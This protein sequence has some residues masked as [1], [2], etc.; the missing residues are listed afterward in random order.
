MA[1]KIQLRRG[2]AAQWTSNNTVVLFAGE[3]GVES[4][5]GKFKIG[6]GSTQWGS[7]PYSSVLPGDLSELSQDAVNTAL[8]AGTGINKNYND[9][10]NTLTLSVDG[11][12]L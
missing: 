2:T 8:T 3:P 4:D 11:T 6:D 1:T 5:T 9:A 7:L 12:Y 10:A